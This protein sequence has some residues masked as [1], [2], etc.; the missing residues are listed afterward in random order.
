MALNIEHL[1]QEYALM[2]LKRSDLKAD[3]FQQF[4][5]WFEE[6]SSAQV[7]EPNA[8]VL[9]TIDLEGYPTGR[10]VLLK[11]FSKD[12]FVF[13][14]NY[15]SGKGREI[16]LNKKVSL[17]FLWKEIH[18]QVRVH[19]IAQ[20]TSDA[21][22]IKYFQSRPRKSQIGAW[23][24][25]QSQV[26]ESRQVLLD[27]YANVEARFKEKEILPKPANWGGYIVIPRSFEFWQGRPSRLH[28][29]FRYQLDHAGQWVIDRL[30]P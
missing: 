18:R 5:T 1:R 19:G 30:A 10:V 28:D 13:Y 3:P 12:G 15:E 20:K 6:A 21:Q 17:T 24:S 26:I 23:T 27:N 11:G 2:E 4:E 9:S 7:D 8:M 25:P 29:R 16:A 22:A 14:T